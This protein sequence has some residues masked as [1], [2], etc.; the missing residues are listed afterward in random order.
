MQQEIIVET[1]ESMKDYVP[2]LVAAS[3]KLANDI[4]SHEGGWPDYL[5]AYLDGIDWL[6]SAFDGIQRLDGEILS[7]FKIDS[8]RLL[9]DQLRMALEQ[10]DFVSI[11]DLLQYEMSPLLH[12][13]EVELKEMVH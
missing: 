9:I 3:E 11:C 5:L 12:T 6:T 10:Q 2:K 1:L 8:L 7:P 13:Y 4:Q